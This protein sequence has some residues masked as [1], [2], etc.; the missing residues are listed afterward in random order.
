MLNELVKK[1]NENLECRDDLFEQE[2]KD[3]IERARKEVQAK[4]DALKAKEQNLPEKPTTEEEDKKNIE[5]LRTIV[6]EADKLF[7]ENKKKAE[8][9]NVTEE[10]QKGEQGQGGQGQGEQGEKGEPQTPRV[11]DT[12]INNFKSESIEGLETADP[13]LSRKNNVV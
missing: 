13:W 9:G 2:K 5:S 6:D 7:Y 8:S 12:E 4:K 11:K 3:K 10:K 1:Y